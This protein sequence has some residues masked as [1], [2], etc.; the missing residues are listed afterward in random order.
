VKE[1]K[2]NKMGAKKQKLITSVNFGNIGS[3]SYIVTDKLIKE[4]ESSFSQ[5]VRQLI[6]LD[7]CIDA[8]LYKK[9]Q[10]KKLRYKRK[11]IIENIKEEIKLKKQIE[12]QLEDFGIDI[13]DLIDED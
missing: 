8:P 3:L 2:N 9:F 11:E 12:D 6:L 7:N 4:K 10:I 1:D 5:Y 13:D